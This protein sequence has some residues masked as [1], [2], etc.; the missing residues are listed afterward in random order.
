MKDTVTVCSIIRRKVKKMA[1]VVITKENYEAEVKNSDVPVLIDFWATW[2]GP[3]RMMAPVIEELSDEADGKYKVCSVN[4][5]DE[6][7]LASQFSISLIPTVVAVKGGEVSGTCVGVKPKE[8][9]LGL[10]A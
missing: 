10:L 2:C 5:D 8:E 9:L 4:V 6:P 3:C 1:A 7:E